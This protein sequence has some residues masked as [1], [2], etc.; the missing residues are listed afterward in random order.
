MVDLI[1]A[2]SSAWLPIFAWI[3]AASAPLHDVLLEL[4]FANSDIARAAHNFSM[5][6]VSSIYLES[7]TPLK[8]RWAWA[9]GR[10]TPFHSHTYLF[11][12]NATGDGC[13]CTLNK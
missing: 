13:L 9:D 3:R 10:I 5:R 12:G 8:A 1:S 11:V 6:S 7:E 4:P 2:S